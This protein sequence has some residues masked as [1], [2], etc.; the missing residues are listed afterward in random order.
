[1]M[2]DLICG[3]LV[4]VVSVPVAAWLLPKLDLYRNSAVCGACQRVMSGRRRAHP[5]PQAM[6]CRNC[7]IHE[8]HQQV[9]TMMKT[10][11]SNRSGQPPPAGSRRLSLAY[12]REK[13]AARVKRRANRKVMKAYL[14]SF[15]HD[16]TRLTMLSA[17]AADEQKRRDQHDH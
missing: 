15:V 3:L 5:R 2:S 12:C 7:R 4:L 17:V 16:L 8:D 11:D 10:E 6:R 9:A 14:R 13:L 1:M